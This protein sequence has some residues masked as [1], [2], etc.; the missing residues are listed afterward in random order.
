MLAYLSLKAI[1]HFKDLAINII[2][3]FTK[4]S[5]YKNNCKIYIRAKAHKIVSRQTKG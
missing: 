1:Q 5:P 2:I 4:L 3:N